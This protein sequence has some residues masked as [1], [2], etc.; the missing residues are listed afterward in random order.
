MNQIH[1]LNSEQVVVSFTH[2]LIPSLLLSD[3]LLEDFL[4]DM[5]IMIQKVEGIFR[6]LKSR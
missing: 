5:N 3:K 4:R 6:V 1:D 2:D